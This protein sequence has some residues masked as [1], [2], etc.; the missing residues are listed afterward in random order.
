MLQGFHDA[1]FVLESS[2]VGG[3]LFVTFDGK[4]ITIVIHSE[5]NSS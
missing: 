5:L 4:E 1:K 3:F 2:K